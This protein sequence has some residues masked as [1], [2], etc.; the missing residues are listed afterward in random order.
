[1]STPPG[2]GSEESVPQVFDRIADTARR[3]HEQGE[4]L[5]PQTFSTAEPVFIEKASADQTVGVTV[6]DGKVDSIRIDSA[7]LTERGFRG[8]EPVLVDVINAALEAAQ[9]ANLEQ[10]A[11]INKG[12]GDLVKN[13]GGLQADLHAAYLG[14]MRRLG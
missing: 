6:V 3:I 5:S 4:T 2:H 7:V 13:L 11:E 14:D 10:L 12:F 1:M 9:A 8:V